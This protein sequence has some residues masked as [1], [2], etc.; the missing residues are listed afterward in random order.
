M[1]LFKAIKEIIFKVKD[2]DRLE[3]DYSA[4]IDFATEGRLSKTNYE[5]EGVFEAITD[6]RMELVETV[7]YEER[8]KMREGAVSGYVM[9]KSAGDM[10]VV[11]SRLIANKYPF[12]DGEKIKV[13]LLKE[14]PC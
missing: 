2:Y 5:L 12:K 14:K 7:Q 11:T 4:V 6:S 3:H 10:Q 1:G 13:L 9:Y 8:K